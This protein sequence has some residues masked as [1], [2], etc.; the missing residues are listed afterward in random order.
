M[1]ITLDIII[2]FYISGLFLSLVTA[3]DAKSV[4]GKVSFIKLIIL[5][6]LSWI[7]PILW[8]SRYRTENTFT[9]NS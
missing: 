1:N 4:I 2:F 6:S 5:I 7:A 9:Y 3:I 8:V